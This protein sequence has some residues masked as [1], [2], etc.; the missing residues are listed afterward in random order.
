MGS[1]SAARQVHA[2]AADLEE[3]HHVQVGQPDGLDHEEVDRQQLTGVL[4]DKLPPGVRAALG[5]RGHMVAAEHVPDGH[6][7]AAIAEL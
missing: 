1:G 5:R 4:P 2:P 6:M 3:E 7:G